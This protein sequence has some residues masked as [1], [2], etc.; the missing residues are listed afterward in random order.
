[1]DSRGDHASSLCSSGPVSRGHRHGS[2]MHAL[3]GAL[4]DTNLRRE[5]EMHGL[6]PDTPGV[7]MFALVIV[8]QWS[9]AVCPMVVYL[10][11]NLIHCDIDTK[12]VDTC[13]YTW[14]V[15]GIFDLAKFAVF[16]RRKYHFVSLLHFFNTRKLIKLV[17]AGLHNRSATSRRATV[18]NKRTRPFT[19][20]NGGPNPTVLLISM[21]HHQMNVRAGECEEH[22]SSSPPIGHNMI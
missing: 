18:Q 17:F 5:R 12:T 9:E 20:F 7:L 21:L 13:L 14:R 3:S 4:R 8:M 1:M 16:I 10:L 6:F 22:S 15:S 11:K 19:I 2:L